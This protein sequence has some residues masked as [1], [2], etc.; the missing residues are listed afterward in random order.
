M[1][2][3][4]MWTTTLGGGMIRDA[5]EERAAG[6]SNLGAVHDSDI[7]TGR[8]AQIVVRQ[9]AMTTDPPPLPHHDPAPAGP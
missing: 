2:N 3:P 4:R 5:D 6:D 8:T 9:A 7:G 1:T